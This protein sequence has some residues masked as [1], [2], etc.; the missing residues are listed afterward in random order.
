M[1][2]RDERTTKTTK[3]QTCGDSFSY[4]QVVYE[5]GTPQ[6]PEYFVMPQGGYVSHVAYATRATASDGTDYETVTVT[7]ERSTAAI[8]VV[9]SSLDAWTSK[10]TL[11]DITTDAFNANDVLSVASV[12]S[13]AGIADGTVVIAV[14]FSG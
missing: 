11:G 12:A 1:A 4:F 14:Q 7:N 2:I 8:A 3:S 10:F 6:G 9:G 13:G 5:G